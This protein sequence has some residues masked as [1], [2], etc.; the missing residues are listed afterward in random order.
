MMEYLIVVCLFL[1][2]LFILIAGVG[3][4]R[5]PDTL[6]RAHALAKALTLGIMLVLLALMF[7]LNDLLSS[8]KLL[9][10]VIFQFV[11]IPIAGHVFALYAA[12]R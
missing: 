10:A 7:Q 4:L 2:V 9:V 6:C 8:C 12:K 11:T 1:G 5:M 3:V